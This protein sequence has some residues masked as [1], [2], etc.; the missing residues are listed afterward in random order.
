MPYRI[1]ELLYLRQ[2]TYQTIVQ[3]LKKNISRY[4]CRWVPLRP[5][6]NR[7]LKL[8]LGR[9]E[10]A[11]LRLLQGLALKQLSALGRMR[12]VKYKTGENWIALKRA[13][14]ENCREN[15]ATFG[16]HSFLCTQGA[17]YFLKE[18]FRKIFQPSYGRGLKHKS[19]YL[20][21]IYSVVYKKNFGHFQQRW[22]QQ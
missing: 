7:F 10:D 16:I 17:R 11:G 4:Y 6:W 5:R 14:E 9:E 8:F 2:G 20:F 21:S 22:C 13:D 1:Y 19:I 15:E 18:E 12:L 3:S